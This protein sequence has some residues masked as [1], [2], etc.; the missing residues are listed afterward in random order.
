MWWVDSRYG[1][2]L[3]IREGLAIINFEGRL[4]G[5]SSKLSPSSSERS[6][7]ACG[8][9]AHTQ[10]GLAELFR[11]LP[12]AANS[13]MRRT[14]VCPWSV[15]RHG[16]IVGSRRS[17]PTSTCTHYDVPLGYTPTRH[18]SLDVPT[19]PVRVLRRDFGT[20]LSR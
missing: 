11:P 17:T 18:L 12:T 3:H 4:E 20:D 19:V 7:A 13:E 5:T 16:S 10:T 9:R 2:R 15:R 8:R 1:N 14:T 6:L